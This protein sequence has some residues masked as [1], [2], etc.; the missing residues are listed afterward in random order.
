[1][2]WL[3]LVCIIVF[4]LLGI[5][6]QCQNF[7]PN[8]SFEDTV[9]CPTT[10]NQVDKAMFWIN[11]TQG[12]PDYFNACNQGI[13][14]LNVPYAGF[15]Y[16]PAKN[17]VA[18]A[19]F[20]GFQKGMTNFREYI[21]TKLTDT[22]IAGRKYLVS[23]FVNLSNVSQYSL[24]NIGAYFSSTQVTSTNSVALA[25]TPQIENSSSVQLSDSVN[26][27]L[28]QDTLLS[29]GTELYVTIG[30]FRPDNQTDT[31][32]LGSFGGGNVAY[33]YIDDVSIIDVESLGIS[34][35]VEKALKVYPVPCSDFLNIETPLHGTGKLVDLLG[36]EVKI[37]PIEGDQAINLAD[38]LPGV[39]FLHVNTE[40]GRLIRKI[41]VQR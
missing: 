35:E 7:I 37:F 4:H 38:L 14:Q 36:K 39:Y 26:W 34:L 6:L 30:N 27:M 22:L 28:I 17:G 1:M 16:Q 3:R 33:Y 25:Y 15:G 8:P 2:N 19:G 21:Q 40:K 18:F 20:Y 12:S 13:Y 24:S 11:P 41:I 29:D 5:G 31:V 23:F 10:L 9:S 32:F